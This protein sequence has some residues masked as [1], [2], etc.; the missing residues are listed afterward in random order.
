MTIWVVKIGGSLA[1]SAALPRWLD[2]IATAGAGRVVLVPGG[3]RWADAVREAQKQEDFDDR[4]AHRKALRAM[5][6]FG[7]ILAGMRGNLVPT[8]AIAQMREV[9]RKDH[10]PVWM[11][12]EM[13][14]ADARIPETWEVT[15]DSLAAWLAGELNASTLLL[16]KSLQMSGA[17]PG[18]EE[19]VRRGWVDAAFAEFASGAHFRTVLAGRDDEM[20]VQVMLA[21][22]D[23]VTVGSEH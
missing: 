9:L 5:E 15:S 11:P 17:Q 7:K 18:I 10:V 4:V 2:I 3:G 20:K 12:Y 8:S 21:A 16:V 22:A 6:E 19:L 14:I 1:E 13:A 23:A